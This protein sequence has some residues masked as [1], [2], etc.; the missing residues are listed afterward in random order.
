MKTKVATAIAE[1]TAGDVAKTLAASVKDQL[2][3][4]KPSLVFLFASTKQPLKELVPAFGDEFKGATFLGCST[5]GEFTQSGDKEGAASI[6]AVVGDFKI[7]SA[8]GTGL[9][10]DVE[11]TITKLVSELPMEVEGYP[12][13]T[14]VLLVDGLSGRGEEVTLLAAMM[15]GE[16]VRL[17]GGAAGDD[18]RMKETYVACNGQVQTDAVVISKIYSKVPLGVGVAHGHSPIGGPFQV[19]RAE[20]NI[21]YE[22]DGK[23]AWEVW[24]DV[25]REKARASGMDPETLQGGDVNKFLGVYEGGLE[26]GEEFKVRVPIGKVPGGAMAFAC[27]IPESTS[28]HIM[29]SD[30]DRQIQSAGLAARRAKDQLG[31]SAPAGAVVFDCRCRKD[32]LGNEFSKAVTTIARELGAPIAGFEAYGEVAMN[33]ADL[34]GFHNT[35]TVV[36]AFP[37]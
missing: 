36:L 8:I 27:G 13:C 26:V 9:R 3:G 22:L 35:T 24:L 16:S 21:V 1:G 12:H 30:G 33:M 4:D 15:L 5:A 2:G 7:F 17:A 11:G 10:D 23:P 28:M 34:S 14:A 19:T 32:L 20:G 6:F 25:T 29:D 18:L 31:G 37:K